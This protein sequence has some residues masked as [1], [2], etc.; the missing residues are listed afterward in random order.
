M[1]G[2]DRKEILFGELPREVRP[3]GEKICYVK[4]RVEHSRQMQWQS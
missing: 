3:E 2:R 4:N 1:I